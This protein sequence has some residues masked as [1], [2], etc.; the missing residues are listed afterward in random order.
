MW[1]KDFYQNTQIYLFVSLT[2]FFSFLILITKDYFFVQ[3]TNSYIEYVHLERSNMEE[4]TS[5]WVSDIHIDPKK[6]EKIEQILEQ[7]HRQKKEDDFSSAAKINIE[8]IPQDFHVSVVDYSALIYT[9][10]ESHILQ[11]IFFGMHMEIY[12][13]LIDVRGKMKDGII[14]IYGP[15]KMKKTEFLS[16][17]IHEFAHFVDLY[18]LEKKVF[19]DTSDIFY[20]ISW[21]STKVIKSNQKQKDF[22]S[23]YAMTNKYEDFAESFTYYLLHNKDF[24][25]K[26]DWS[27]VL[28]EKYD[29]FTNYLFQKEEFLDTHFQQDSHHSLQ[30]YYRD[31]TKIPF[32]LEKLLQYIK[33]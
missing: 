1:K 18:F 3:N 15:E 27:P 32:S 30:E 17:T 9:F 29:F 13:N 28:K 25:K 14:K 2:L 12:Q 16:V 4:G 26:S 20:N 24:L 7:N 10:F 21:E 33:K 23:G 5:T 6:R 11:S 31:I 22:V 19:S 8:Y